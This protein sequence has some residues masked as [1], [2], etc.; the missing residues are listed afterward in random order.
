[1]KYSQRIILKNIAISLLISLMGMSVAII[2]IILL[3]NSVP[4]NSTPF[5]VFSVI[6]PIIT[7]IM[8]IIVKSK[9]DKR[10]QQDI[11]ELY[12]GEL[13]KG[14]TQNLVKEAL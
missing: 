2:T 5:V 4:I 3:L 11:Y 12:A 7:I 13:S 8:V 6:T 10:H 9:Q 14:D 1:M